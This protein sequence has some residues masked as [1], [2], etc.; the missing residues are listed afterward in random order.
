MEF[1]GTLAGR[2]RLVWRYHLAGG[3]PAAGAVETK[4]AEL[5]GLLRGRRDGVVIAL[6]AECRPDCNAAR[7]ALSKLL[8]EAAHELH[9]TPP[10][11]GAMASTNTGGA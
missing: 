6:S 4:L 10:A 11:A 8:A 9:W 1:R 2:E 5:R 3:V 7:Q